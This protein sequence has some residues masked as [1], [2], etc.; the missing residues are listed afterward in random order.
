MQSA[1]FYK[2]SVLHCTMICI[3]WRCL[4]IWL[5]EFLI[6]IRHIFSFYCMQAFHSKTPRVFSFLPF[7]ISQNKY[8]T[9]CPQKYEGREIPS[10]T[11]YMYSYHIP[12]HHIFI[13]YL[14]EGIYEH[15]EKTMTLEEKLLIK[16]LDK[17]LKC[18]FI[19]LSFSSPPSIVY[20]YATNLELLDYFL[21][22]LIHFLYF[23]SL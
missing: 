5:L 7:T 4:T 22:L 16:E 23:F 14:K 13:S 2:K 17:Y 8:K 18:L 15:S 10:V 6:K 20:I 21:R 19:D 9:R 12:P 11:L 1:W 3:D